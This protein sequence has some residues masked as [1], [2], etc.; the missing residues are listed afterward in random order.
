MYD[1]VKEK[2]GGSDHIAVGMGKGMGIG[3]EEMTI[4]II[5]QRH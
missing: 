2:E 1:T 5:A 4:L 3:M